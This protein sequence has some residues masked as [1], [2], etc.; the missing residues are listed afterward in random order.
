MAFGRP[1]DAEIANG[2]Q[3]MPY[4]A[5]ARHAIANWF[6]LSLAWGVIRGNCLLIHLFQEQ[7]NKQGIRRPSSWRQGG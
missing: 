2:V 3:L 1:A 4:G 5:Y 7:L 6:Q